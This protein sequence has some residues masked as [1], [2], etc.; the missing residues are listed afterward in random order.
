M[1]TTFFTKYPDADPSRFVF[2]DG[3]VWF[4]LN[5]DNENRLLD[6]ESD[7]YQ[8]TPSWT[9]YLTSYKERE[10][11]IW[12]ADG[13]VQP[14]K[15]NTTM[16]DINKF[17]VY[18]TEDKYFEAGLPPFSITNNPENYKKNSYLIAII[19]AYVSTYVCGISAQHMEFNKDTPG[20]IT[21]MVRYHL[22]YQI[23]KFLKDP[24]KLDRY[25]SHVPN[26]VKKHKPTSPVWTDEF[27]Q[28]EEEIF[29]WLSKQKDKSTPKTQK[30]K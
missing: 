16:K 7:A 20:I 6:I 5:P 25:I 27:V 3:K 26:F 12:F 1:A 4:K 2:K 30:V 28:G 24:S 9:K 11:G 10:F 21:S 18:V 22:Y 29:A 15:K 19:A 13:T 14:Y 23:S 8:R 17:K